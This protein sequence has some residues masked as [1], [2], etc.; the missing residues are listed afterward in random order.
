MKQYMTVLS[1]IASICLCTVLFLSHPLEAAAYAKEG[2]VKYHGGVRFRYYPNHLIMADTYNKQTIQYMAALSKSLGWKRVY[3]E[4]IPPHL[5]DYTSRYFANRNII[6][7]EFSASVASNYEDEDEGENV[8]YY[9]PYDFPYDYGNE[10]D[11]INDS[12]IG[13]FYPYDGGYR[14]YGG[15]SGREFGN[16]LCHGRCG[17]KHH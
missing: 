15:Y 5:R 7:N 10:F 3:I 16:G 11:D 1:T 13:F 6:L 2:I 12:S 4:D 8:N 9:V 14:E 17:G